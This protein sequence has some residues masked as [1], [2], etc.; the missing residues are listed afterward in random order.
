MSSFTDKTLN[1]SVILVAA[2][3]THTQKKMWRYKKVR[4][5]NDSERD[6]TAAAVTMIHT[7]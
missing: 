4:R 5:N 2:T 3:H 1:T 6:A 7:S